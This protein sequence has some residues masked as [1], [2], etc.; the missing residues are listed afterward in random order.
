MPLPE[1]MVGCLHHVHQAE[2]DLV[3]QLVAQEVGAVCLAQL[4]QIVGNRSHCLDLKT[5]S[6]TG[7]RHVK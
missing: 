3:V 5:I 6:Y 4:L 2:F 7:Y 1:H